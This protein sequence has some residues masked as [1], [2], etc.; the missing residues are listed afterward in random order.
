M[1]TGLELKFIHGGAMCRIGEADKQ[2]IAASIKRE[3][4]LARQYLC[5]QVFHGELLGI[6]TSKIEQR[7]AEGARGEFSDFG[8]AKFFG[9]E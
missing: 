5:L 2:T 8:L 4:T 1:E 6:D 3:R 9:L 7:K